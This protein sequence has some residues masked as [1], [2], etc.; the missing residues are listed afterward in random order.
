MALKCNSQA[1]VA[2]TANNENY[3]SGSPCYAQVDKSGDYNFK[4]VSPGKYLVQTVV[5]NKNLKLH[6]SPE[7]LEFEVGK[8][9]LALKDAFKVSKYCLKKS[10]NII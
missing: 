3:A 1:P 10:R 8:D 7:F 4:D 6:I 5:E 9:T 2:L